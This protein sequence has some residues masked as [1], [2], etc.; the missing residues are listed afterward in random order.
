M[1]IFFVEK[2]SI[3]EGDFG[4]NDFL[5]NLNTKKRFHTQKNQ[6]SSMFRNVVKTRLTLIFK[7]LCT[8]FGFKKKLHPRG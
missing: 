2:K 3:L 8:T 5:K 4:E 1:G 6:K 7:K